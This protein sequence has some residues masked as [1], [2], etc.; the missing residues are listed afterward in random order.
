MRFFLRQQNQTE[1][2]GF[3]HVPLDKGSGVLRF[4]R[5]EHILGNRRR[6]SIPH[7]QKTLIGRTIE[8]NENITV[9]IG[10]VTLARMAKEELRL[11]SVLDSMKR[12]QGASVT[13]VT[14]ALVS[15]AMQMQGLYGL[16]EGVDK[17]DLYRTGKL[18]GKNIETVVRH[19]DGQLRNRYH[20]SF[21]KVFLDWSASYVDGKPTNLIR[22][23]HTKDHRPDRPQVAIGMAMESVTGL[24]YGCAQHGANLEGECP[25]RA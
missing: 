8:P 18:L 3:H 13:D 11:P 22:F 5:Q 2:H 9:P 6:N 10:P 25:L 12:D 23:G 19:I 7:A 21:E 1:A 14:V 4:G 20:I 16:D 24:L 17:N 15:H